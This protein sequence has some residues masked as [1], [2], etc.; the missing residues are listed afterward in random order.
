MHPGPKLQ[1]HNPAAYYSILTET[2]NISKCFLLI[3]TMKAILS[4]VQVHVELPTEIVTEVLKFLDVQTLLRTK[5]V[6]KEWQ[7]KCTVVIDFKGTNSNSFETNQELK[8]AVRRYKNS[9]PD[10]D[11]ELAS[12]YGWPINNWD[13]SNV[14]DFSKIFDEQRSFNDDISSWDFCNATNMSYMFCRAT[15]FNQ[16][17][18]SWNTA[19]VI[20]MSCMFFQATSFNQDISSWNTASV[21]DMDHMF[22]RATSFNQD[23]SSWNTASVI[24]MI[25]MFCRATSFNQDMS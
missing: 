12:T 8:D 9:N 24:N 22:F 7:C 19:S 18:S 21:T 1:T 25:R 10:E 20:N 14:E 13:V 6:C 23:I 17:I 11:E 3:T 15:S 4:I 16:D 5:A 2:L